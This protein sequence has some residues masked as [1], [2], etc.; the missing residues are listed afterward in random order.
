MDHLMEAPKSNEVLLIC[1][2]ANASM[3]SRT[4]AKDQV[5]GPYGI[6]HVNSA[7]RALHD[8]LDAKGMC[9]SASFFPKPTHGSW[10]HPRSKQLHQLDHLLISRNDLC[11]V[12][13]AS[14]W[15]K[16]TVESDHAPL[17]MKLRIARNLSKQTESK[18]KLINREL[19]R[20]SHRRKFV[21]T[22]STRSSWSQWMPS[23]C[24]LIL[25]SQGG[26]YCS[27]KRNSY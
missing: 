27:S 10:R 23:L 17:Q 4:H 5:L 8:H 26:S 16:L 14:V 13:D 11:R 6:E 15:N 7:G 12:R 25:L 19:L 3:G 21:Q 9:S 20:K 18:G 2:D 22:E 1:I 24:G